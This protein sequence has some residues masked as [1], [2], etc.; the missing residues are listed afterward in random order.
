MSTGSRSVCGSVFLPGVFLMSLALPTSPGAA[1][2]ASLPTGLPQA[3]EANR[4]QVDSS[5][6]FLSRAD[7]LVLTID[8]TG[9][10]LALAAA[11]PDASPAAPQRTRRA[12]LVFR[13]MQP[14]VEI[15][16]IEPLQGR[17]AYL[18]GADRKAWIEAVPSF[19]AVRYAGVYP[20]IDLVLRGDHRRLILDFDVAA[21]ADRQAIDLALEGDDHGALRLRRSDRGR[22][23]R[24]TLEVGRAAGATDGVARVVVDRDGNTFLAGRTP[25]GDLPAEAFVARID[26]G[27]TTPA[28]VTYFG[29]S[30]RDVPLAIAAAPDGTIVVAGRTESPDFPGAGVPLRGPADGFVLRLAPDGSGPVTSI[31]LGGDG[32][33]EAR[34]L[35]IDGHG[36]VFVG[37][38]GLLVALEGLHPVP[39][40]LPAGIAVEAL[41]FDAAGRLVFAG[42]RRQ[43]DRLQPF[44]GGADRAAV[45]IPVGGD[46][47][48]TALAFDDAGTLYVTGRRFAGE[49]GF[50]AVLDAAAWTTSAVRD[51]DGAPLAIAAA[52][53]GHAWIV[54]TRGPSDD[55]RSFIARVSGSDA[56]LDRLRPIPPNSMSR[57]T[58]IALDPDGRPVV[59]GFEDRPVVAGRES[60]GMG[61]DGAPPARWIAAAA[62]A[63]L[64]A[65]RPL[66]G[67]TIGPAAAGCP[68]T[69]QFDNSAGT[70]LWQT[71]ANWSTDIL[72]GPADDVCIP[73][74]KN[75]TLSA[76]AHTIST[77]YVEA[78]GA[79][80]VTNGTLTLGAAS[81]VNGTL[82]MRGGTLGG[83]ADITVATLLN[84]TSGTFSGAGSLFANGGAAISG[85]SL[86]DVTAHRILSTSGTVTWTGTGPIRITEWGVIHNDGI[87]D[88][89]SDAAIISDVSGSFENPA[90]KIFRK[91]AGTGTT[92]VGVWFIN[93]GSL[94]IE[95]GTV[96]LTTGG[97]NGSY[98]GLAGTTL[99]F[100]GSPNNLYGSTVNVPRVMLTNGSA[101]ISG[102]YTA[103]SATI[104]NNGTLY[105]NPTATVAAIGDTVT[106]SNP[107]QTGGLVLN[108]GEA[109][110][111]TTLTLNGG[112]LSGTDTV[113]VS[114]AM[115]WNL[116]TMNGAGVVNANGGLAIGGTG[117]KDISGG[118][119]L[120]T[121]GATTWTGTN[122][123]RM[124][125]GA[126]IRNAGTWDVQTDAGMLASLGGT[127]RF[128]NL[129]SGTFQRTAGGGISTI[130]VDVTNAGTIKLQAGATSITGSYHQTAGLLSVE[131]GSLSSSGTLQ[132]DGGTLGGFG[133]IT[134]NVNLLADHLSPGTSPG[135]LS[136]AGTLNL[137]PSAAFGVEIGGLTPGTEHD[138]AV[139]SDAVTLAGTLNVTLV[140][141]FVPADG[142]TFTIM[143]FPSATG[144]F[145]AI[146]A[147]PLPGGRAWRVV[148]NPTSVVLE[149][150]ADLDGDGVGNLVD[151]APS[152]ASAWSLPA[153]ASGLVFGADDQ[154]LSWDALAAQA[155]PGTTY[156][157]MRGS[158]AELPSGGGAAE[159]CLA[160]DS[161]ATQ[162][163][164]DAS[165]EIGAGFYYLVR[166]GNVCGAGT[167]GTTSGGAPRN[168]AVC[169]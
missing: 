72:P 110:A 142:A 138:R 24:V 143:T 167:Y 152:D 29:G 135:S 44:V 120:N 109:I 31:L 63:G 95:S 144:S 87:W 67:S 74:G 43:G 49:P 75:V 116:G 51:I 159:T 25:A 149:V 129:A 127:G 16:G 20:G 35:A 83:A 131:A 154:T 119:V 162:V 169:P 130:S 84:W 101:A 104:I 37:G 17:V 106:I 10:G 36:A 90:G 40:A 105:L 126:I 113:N 98:T 62:P 139:V 82:T 146:D 64:V 147:P 133:T 134:G 14:S 153:E 91:T 8:A 68:G 27:E 73:A 13:G 150:L 77:L 156:D 56:T 9:I 97:G 48:A 112:S 32:D 140:N 164:D 79:L 71:A 114:G 117:P 145:A 89:Q 125:S 11:D 155:G 94:S 88:A 38:N 160:I 165:P 23:V 100:A 108:S 85:P 42:S 21:E 102:T 26:R 118:R 41:A 137:G 60:A 57:A 81:Q 99:Q 22:S 45:P 92:T 132:I 58:G 34:A 161:P 78:D 46:A 6:M 115:T 33:D 2:D 107:Q 76:L 7:G 111:T 47:A 50:V 141:G 39:P 52:G 5:V 158:L 65:V 69:I 168:T 12:R 80:T 157:L 124:G 163:S 121:F 93:D 54:G 59:A 28:F 128:D 53:E 4:G 86:K 136:I 151:C 1:P 123:I 70:G 122:A 96:A 66:S 166:G 15:R 3:F 55:R 18:G 19:A 103:S 148:Y 30:G 61:D